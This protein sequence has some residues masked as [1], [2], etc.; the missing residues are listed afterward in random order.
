[1]V[2]GDA[3]RYPADVAP[4]AAVA[5]PTTKALIQLRSLLVEGESVWLL[6]ETY[7]QVPTLA[8]E[9]TLPCLQ[10]IMPAEVTLP[11]PSAEIVL[12]SESR[13]MVA[14]TDVAFP[15]FFR[16]RTC[17]MGSYYGVRSGGELIAMGG[18]RLMLE[19]YA[20]ISGVCTRREHRAKGL[21]AS[22]IWHLVRDHRRAGVASWLHVGSENPHAI[23]LYLWMGF[24]VV[25]EVIAASSVAHRLNS[26]RSS[27]ISRHSPT[28]FSLISPVSDT[29]ESERNPR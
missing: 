29:T 2:A 13:E 27:G 16:P 19:G 7:P 18:E 24:K 21:A 22:V 6:G 20:E 8:F 15:G 4:L 26:R 9:E 1:M 28:S 23:G 11:S 14:L 10:M 12:L 5:E 3:C 17:E 25:R